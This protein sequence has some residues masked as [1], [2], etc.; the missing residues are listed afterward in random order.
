MRVSVMKVNPMTTKWWLISMAI[1]CLPILYFAILGL[2]SWRGNVPAPVDGRFRPGPDKPN[3]VSSQSDDPQHQIE[4]FRLR[5]ADSAAADWQRLRTLLSET[6]RTEIVTG[7]DSYL[8]ATCTS[9][10][11]RFVDDVEFL[12][13]PPGGKIDIRSASRVGY[14]DLGANRARLEQL[15]QRFDAR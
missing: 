3:W 2:L 7:T 11:F 13:D 8:H 9:R 15:R 5:S 12:L 14:S 1:V 6:P 10:L 4:P